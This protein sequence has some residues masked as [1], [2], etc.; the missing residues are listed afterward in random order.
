MTAIR[1]TRLD[2]VIESVANGKGAWCLGE[3]PDGRCMLSLGATSSMRVPGGSIVMLGL[4]VDPIVEDVAPPSIEFD[5]AVH[6]LR[7]SY[8]DWERDSTQVVTDNELFD[9][10]LASI[11]K[12]LV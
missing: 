1:T 12:K 2:S 3:A 5:V 11:Q 7:R 6:D 10:L 4:T 9:Q 8:E